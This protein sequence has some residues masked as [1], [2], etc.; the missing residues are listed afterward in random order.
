MD[1]SII[2]LSYNTQDLTK[3]CL[4][5]IVKSLDKTK[6]KV[7]IIVI[8]NASKDD[9]VQ[10]LKTYEKKHKSK[11]ISLKFIYNKENVGYPRGNNQGM[12]VAKGEYILLLNSDVIVQNVNFEKLLE[13]MRKNPKIGALTVKVNLPVGGIDPASHR[14]FPTPWNSFCYFTKLEMVLGRIPGLKSLFGGYH[15]TK[16]NLKRIHEIDSPTGAFFLS[17]K[18]ILDKVHGFDEDYFMYGEDLDLAFKI[19]QLKY[20]II[21]YPLYTVVHFKYK[22]GLQGKQ[23]KVRS[24]TK[25]YFYESMKIFF[26]KHY[27]K[28]YPFFVRW[29]VYFFIDLKSKMV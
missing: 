28:K 3:Q 22:S 14:G 12:K 15:L 6:V 18:E 2:I 27:S 24:K 10:L 21:Y 7:E 9:S 1:L 16:Y 13:Y 25:K 29:I 23:K 11:N 17:P 5:S 19:K 26:K 4:D 8:D 20:K